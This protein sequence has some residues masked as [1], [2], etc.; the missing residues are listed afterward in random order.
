MKEGA[1][2]QTILS[3]LYYSKGWAN[4]DRKLGEESWVYIW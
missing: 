1:A 2:G 4:V 3:F